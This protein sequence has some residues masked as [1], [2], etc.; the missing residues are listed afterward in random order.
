MTLAAGTGKLTESGALSVFTGSRTGRSPSDRFIA[1]KSGTE[2]EIAWGKVNLP[3]EPEKAEKVRE[4][5]IRYLSGGRELIRLDAWVGADSRFGRPVIVFTDSPWHALFA[6]NIFRRV[7]VEPDGSLLDPDGTALP[8]RNPL[9]ILAAPYLTIDPRES[10]LRSEVGIILDL[11]EGVITIH[12]TQYAGEIKK[13]VFTAMNF[14]LPF[15]GVLPMHCSAN[16]GKDGGV[17]LFFGLSGTGK[18]T[19]SADSSRQLI[20]DDEHGW[21]DSGVFNFEGGCYAKCI[22]LSREHEPE[23][24]NAIRF[25]AILENVVVDPRS[26]I[27]DF[28]DGSVTENTRATYP[29]SHN[30]VVYPG[31]MAGHPTTIFFLVADAFGVMPPIAELAPEQA[32]YYFISGYTAKLAG[33]EAGMGNAVQATFSSCFGEPFLPLH[34]QRYADMLRDRIQKHGTRCYLLNT[35]WSGGPYGVGERLRLP[36]SRAM[37]NAALSGGL[38]KVETYVDPVFGLKVPLSCPGVPSEVLVPENTWK[39]KEEYRR[40]RHELAVQFKENMNRFRGMSPEVLAAG[41]RV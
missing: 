24:W 25:G 10:G 17:A 28:A 29:L 13:S 20:G 41:P 36:W 7:S 4:L 5:I 23:I 15:E 33:T 32:M 22:N 39:D 31:G 19:L 2:G 14:Y 30:T 16:V 1:R 27:P 40:K 35:G 12:G 34:P 6:R 21:S 8:K 38:L 11:D 26:R 37:V 18:T 3:V 9:V